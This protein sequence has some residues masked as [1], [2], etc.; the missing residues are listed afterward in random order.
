MIIAFF[1]AKRDVFCSHN[2]VILMKKHNEFA[3]KKTHH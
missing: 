3:A 1:C 2:G